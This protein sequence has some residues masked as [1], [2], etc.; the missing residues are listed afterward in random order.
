MTVTDLSNPVVITRSGPIVGKEKDGALLFCGVPYSAPPVGTRRFKAAVAPE[1]WQE[2][3]DATRFS[4]AAPQI[5]SGGMMDAPVKWDEDCLYLN[6]CTPGVD[7]ARRPVLV[8]IHGGGYRTG[9]SAIPWYNGNSFACNGNIVVVSIN[10]RLGAFGFTDLSKFGDDYATSGI[11][12]ILDQIVALEWV[13]ENIA[14]FGGDPDR[15]TIAG[16]S[17]GGFSVSTLLGSERAQGLFHRVISQSGAAHATLTAEEGQNVTNLLFETLAI[18]TVAELKEMDALSILRAQNDVDKKFPNLL[19]AVQ[20]FYPVVGNEVLPV[21]PLTAIKSG[22]GAD[23]PVLTGSNKDEATLFVLEEVSETRLERQ[24]AGYGNVALIERYQ[25]LLPGADTTTLSTHL[26]T[27][28]MFKIPAI[29]LA[30]VR[31]GYEADTWLYQ[32]DWESRSG[33]LK[34][35][36]ALEIPFCFNTLTAPGLEIFLGKGELPQGLADEMH[37][38][39]TRFIHG[40]EPSWPRYDIETRATWHFDNTSA[41]VENEENALLEV[42]QGIR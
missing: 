17:A 18:K 28:F 5:P 12:G 34:A 39:W 36:H 13:R 23:V 2:V 6:V 31:A 7:G 8:W 40:D 10:Y 3:R 33:K 38:V 26:A 30:E 25:T 11:N 42:W 15:V 14:E 41:L 21:S 37:A 24:A 9:Q 29:R 19:T 35:T 4:R 22:V 16:E 27:D 20:A 32:F 1:P